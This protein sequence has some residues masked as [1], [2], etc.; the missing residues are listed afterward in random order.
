MK[1]PIGFYDGKIAIIMLA[2]LF[3]I[4]H[5]LMAELGGEAPALMDN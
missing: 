1:N 4:Q 5:L 2:D 3:M